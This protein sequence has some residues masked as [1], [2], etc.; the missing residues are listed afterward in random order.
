MQIRDDTERDKHCKENVCVYF[1]YLKHER[2]IDKTCL[3]N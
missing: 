2:Q 3:Q 1:K